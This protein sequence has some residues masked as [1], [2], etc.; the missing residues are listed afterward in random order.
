MARAKVPPPTMAS[1][2]RQGRQF[3]PV[4]RSIEAEFRIFHRENPHVYEKLV[5]LARQARTN[6]RQTLG[7]GMLFEVLRWEHLIYT[8]DPDFKLNNNYRSYYARLMMKNEPDL[9][10]MFQTRKLQIK[11]GTDGR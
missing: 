5:E 1:M 9:A 2:V 7:I 4:G 10:G 8:T 3:T 6:G 11:D